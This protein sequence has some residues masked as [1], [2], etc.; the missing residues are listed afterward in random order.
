MASF[1]LTR[2]TSYG[3]VTGYADTHPLRRTSSGLE[4]PRGAGGGEDPV[5]KWL[6]SRRWRVSWRNFET[7]GMIRRVYGLARRSVDAL[8]QL[9]RFRS[10][11][12]H[13]E[14]RS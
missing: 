4:P 9:Q 10:P 12:G 11:I 6:V 1:R 5:L 13:V 7:P 2:E 14:H 8:R 3:P